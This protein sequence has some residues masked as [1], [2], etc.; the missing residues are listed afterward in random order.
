MYTTDLSPAVKK[1]Q[2]VEKRIARQ[3]ITD[4]IKDG[5]SLN[6]FNGGDT[7]EL[8]A[9]STKVKD[10]LGA[11]FATDDERLYFWKDGKRCGWVWFVYGNDG[12]DVVCDH[13]ENVQHI[14][15][16]AEALADKLQ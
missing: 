15:G 7:Y 1:R 5:Y 12:W 10:I 13:S 11:M 3:V 2:A 14:M 16:G 6:V 8:P 9:P 4:A